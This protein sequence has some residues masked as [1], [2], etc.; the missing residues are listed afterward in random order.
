[1]SPVTVHRSP[2]GPLLRSLLVPA[3]R[4]LPLP[5]SENCPSKLFFRK[6]LGAVGEK[7][8]SPWKNLEVFYVDSVARITPTQCL[9]ALS[10]FSHVRLFATLW[11]VAQQAPPSMGFF[12]QEY[13]SGFPFPPPGD[14]PDPG[15]EPVSLMSPALAGGFFTT[16]AT[17][18]A[19]LT[20]SIYFLELHSYTGLQT[21]SPPLTP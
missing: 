15:I 3:S 16:S 14:L 6:Q 12:R 19:P 7:L 5:A 11:T 17:W 21:L 1:M 2:W 20:W 8:F 10:Q 9:C 13:W 4:V 18:E